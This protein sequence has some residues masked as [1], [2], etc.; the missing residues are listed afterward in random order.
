MEKRRMTY[1]RCLEQLGKEEQIKLYDDVF[2]DKS[3]EV[4]L[5]KTKAD[6]I[7]VIVNNDEVA[8]LMPNEYAIMVDA[9]NDKD[10]SYKVNVGNFFIPEGFSLIIKDNIPY[11]SAK[12]GYQSRIHFAA[13]I[14]GKDSEFFYT[15]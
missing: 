1:N 9:E 15:E 7:A 11:L 2:I 10:L 12:D 4:C 13:M 5:K 3:Y 6:T 8:Y 14:Y